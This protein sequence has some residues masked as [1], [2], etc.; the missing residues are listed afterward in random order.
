M[1]DIA[2][3]GSTIDV[4]KIPFLSAN[5]SPCLNRSI[6]F[7]PLDRAKWPCSKALLTVILHAEALEKK[8]DKDAEIER[9]FE[10]RRT[11]QKH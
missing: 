7:R 9:K 6:H 3:V 2:T 1:A 8:I 5:S 4:V 10:D 11:Y